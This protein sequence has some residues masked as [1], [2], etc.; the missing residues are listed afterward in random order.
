MEACAQASTGGVPDDDLWETF[1]LERQAKS[2]VSFGGWLVDIEMTREDTKLYAF[3][4]LTQS[5]VH[6]GD[7]PVCLFF[8]SA[9]VRS[10]G[11]LMVIGRPRVSEKLVVMKTSVN[12]KIQRDS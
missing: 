9:V 7:V 5:W 4:P 12:S 8:A 1:H 6:V 10:S 3:S 2:P 11:E